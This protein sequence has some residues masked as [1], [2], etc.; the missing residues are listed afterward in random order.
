MWKMTEYKLVPVDKSLEI[1]RVVVPND[2]IAYRSLDLPQLT[3]NPKRCK[4]L[5]DYLSAMK[6]YR[7]EDGSLSHET[8]NYP[9][10]L[11][12]EVVYALVDG[13]KRPPKGYRT[14]LEL[15]KKAKIPKRLLA[16][17]FHKYL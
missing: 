2:V 5:L 15:V 11:F 7:A 12:D 13:T 8:K 1:V 9:E 10:L 4:K 16:K 6:L 3:K 17:R 14:V